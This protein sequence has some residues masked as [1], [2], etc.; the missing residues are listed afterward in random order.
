V[1]S[2]SISGGAD[3]PLGDLD[4]SR[5]TSGWPDVR[6]LPGLTGR[7]PYTGHGLDR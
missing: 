1:M 5:S 2:N 7:T 3:R 4:G 6:S